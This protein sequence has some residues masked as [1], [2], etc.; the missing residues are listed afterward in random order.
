MAICLVTGGA[1]FIGSHL[2]EAL[3]E[4][5]HLVRVLDNLSTGRLSNLEAVLG[6][7]EFVAGDVCDEPLVNDLMH[8]VDYV[9]HLAA[10]ASVPRSVEAPLESHAAAPLVRL[11]SSMPH[12]GPG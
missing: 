4:H 3:V 1:G 5:G 2:V 7:V 10:L 9:F 12:A 11:P 6:V 8:G